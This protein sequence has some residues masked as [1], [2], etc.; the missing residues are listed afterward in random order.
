MNPHFLCYIIKMTCDQ[1][2]PPMSTVA[3]EFAF[4][5]AANMFEVRRTSLTLEMLEALTCLK[6]WEEGHMGL[7]SWVDDCRH[8]LE[9]LDINQDQD[10]EEINEDE[11]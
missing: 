2:T 5:T 8:E 1:L 10:V 4:S 7:Q 11:E 6:D 3:S 9:R